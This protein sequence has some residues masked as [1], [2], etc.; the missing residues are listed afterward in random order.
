MDTDFEE[1]DFD[2]WVALAKVDPETFEKRRAEWLEEAIQQ[3][4]DDNRKRL[5]GL[6]FQIELV[7]RKSRHPLGACMKLS[8]MM[9]DHWLREL[10]PVADTIEAEKES[11]ATAEV[12]DLSNFTHSGNKQTSRRRGGES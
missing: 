11:S 12:I 6:Q 3:A 9:L 7:R 2:E 10:P 1:F 8:S 5:Q 4:P